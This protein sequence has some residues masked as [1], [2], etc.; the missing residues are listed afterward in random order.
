MKIFLLLLLSRLLFG[1]ADD[2]EEVRQLLS[3]P[4]DVDALTEQVRSLAVELSSTSLLLRMGKN[5]ELDQCLEEEQKYYKHPNMKNAEL[6]KF[7]FG[8]EWT[9]R[10]F[11]TRHFFDRIEFKET[12]KSM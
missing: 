7:M 5:Q 6:V 11:K 2:W 12:C 4:Q 3:N 10:N 8:Y 1:K 9:E